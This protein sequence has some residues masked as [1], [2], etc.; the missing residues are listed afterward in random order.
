MSEKKNKSNF[1]GLLFILNNKAF[2]LMIIVMILSVFL[3]KGMSATGYNIAGIM[4]QIAVLAII[5]IGFTVILGGGQMDLSVGDLV[6]LCG[7]CYGMMS[8]SLPIG[9]AIILVVFIGV[10]CEFANGFMIRFF[11]IPGFVLTL[12]MG[13]VFK[14]IAHIITDGKSVGGLSA[15]VKFLG[16]G[17][18]FGFIP[19]PFVIMGVVVII[20]AIVLNKT[21][22]GRH[23]IATGGNAQAAEVSGIRVGIIKI[24]SL[25]IAG[26]CFAIGSVVLTGRVA[27]AIPTAGDG[28][29]MD[30]I[31]AVVI[32]GTPMHGG[33]AKVVGTLFGVVLIGVI[34]NMLN[35]LGVSSYW[36]WVFK[37]IIIIVAIILDSMAGTVLSKQREK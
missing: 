12:A 21:I 4:R 14:G 36:Q 6:S 7:V 27:S 20:I 15:S 32:G 33:K 29:L 13:L 8:K 19:V 24:T 26:A 16:Q 37:G 9:V 10:L 22:Y 28:Y 5:S 3:T 1:N 17:Q 2:I 34:N 23:V 18:V 11:K 25:M 30:A 31:A 35:L